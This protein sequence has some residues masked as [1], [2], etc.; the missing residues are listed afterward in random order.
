M[1]ENPNQIY[2]DS[3]VVFNDKIDSLISYK[4][5]F[6]G[7]W[8]SDWGYEHYKE[9]KYVP[10]YHQGIVIN[11]QTT[12]CWQQLFLFDSPG[13]LR[14][15]NLPVGVLQCGGVS[16]FVRSSRMTDAMATG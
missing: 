12:S 4:K 2:R 8:H 14:F 16:T 6:F 10:L 9:S 5:W 7:H 3:N 1:E 13:R 11:A 15:E